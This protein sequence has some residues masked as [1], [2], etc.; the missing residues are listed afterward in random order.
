MC[1]KVKYKNKKQARGW[2]GF[3]I[4]K[5]GHKKNNVK[6]YKCPECGKWHLSCNGADDID[7]IIR[8][9]IKEFGKKYEQWEKK[10]LQGNN[11]ESDSSI[12][13]LFAYKSNKKQNMVC[14]NIQSDKHGDILYP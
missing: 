8:K 6:S 13:K 11:L 4:D 3:Y 7:F 5:Y 2:A 12:N 1:K 14:D 10:N 9:R